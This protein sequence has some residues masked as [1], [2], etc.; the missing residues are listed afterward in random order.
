MQNATRNRDGWSRRQFLL[1]SASALGVAFGGGLLARPRFDA[2]PFALGVA[3]GD[4]SSDG[5]VLWT[6]IAPER[7][8]AAFLPPHDIAVEWLVAEDE[9]FARVVRR[10][11]AVARADWAHSVHIEVDG[12]D[13]DRWYWYQFR[14]GGEA[15]ATGRTRTLPAGG[16]AAA[17]LRLA[18]ASCQHY[19]HGYFAAYRHMLGD[20][21]D[22]VLHVGDYIYEGSW[23]AQLRRHESARGAETLADYRNRHA[24]YK[25]DPDL[26]RAHA[27]YPWLVT[28]DDHDVSNDYAG[29]VS[30]Y[31]EPAPQFAA[32]RAA[33]YRAYYEHMPLRARHRP[34]AGGMPLYRDFHFGDLAAISLLDD[35][36]Y[37]SAHACSERGEMVD[38]CAQRWSPAQTMLGATQQRWLEDKL[39]GSDARWN[40][41][42]QQTLIAPFV[43]RGDDDCELVWTD[44]WD[45]Y[46]GARAEL[47]GF[48]AARQVPN[49][50]TLGGDM[51]AFYAA[52]LRA[53]FRDAD[54]PAIA[55]EF[56]GTSISAEGDD[57]AER[58]RHLPLNPHIRYF[59]SRWRGYLR[60]EITPQLWRSDLRIVDDVGDPHSSARTLLTLH[61]ENGR[62]GVQV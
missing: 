55:S 26:Q 3:S 44:G 6:R 13:A 56:V 12:L 43:S 9:R 20:D 61:V 10:G 59:E 37:R 53:D 11:T 19:E 8:D 33:A 41:I 18:V 32:R 42:A 48:I 2:Y 34:N 45:G 49:V 14:C 17:R 36:Q 52:D 54:S 51:H 4:P 62:A 1:G 60:C 46:A 39:A 50:V 24:C 27:A 29:L 58:A 35:R 38:D 16:A 25:S 47:L 22:L 57:Y 5:F 28:W 7:S 30:H 21:L 31:G 23:G 15:S 40:V